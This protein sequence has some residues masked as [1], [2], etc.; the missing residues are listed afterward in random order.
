MRI[1]VI[2]AGAAGMV[3]A[4]EAAERGADVLLLE[5]NSKAGVKILMSGGTRCNLTQD[6]DARGITELSGKRGRFLQ[7]SVGAF[8]PR[9]RGRNVP[10]FG[11]RHEDRIDRKNL[12]TQRSRTGCSRF[13][14]ASRG[15]QRLQAS[16]EVCGERLATRR[17]DVAS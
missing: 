10:W 5:K 3:A 7:P 1:V 6:T 15:G 17:F 9:C 14:S 8:P 12:S 2:G 4:A 16:F 11:G 13:S